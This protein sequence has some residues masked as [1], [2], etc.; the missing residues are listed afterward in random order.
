MSTIH[1][2]IHGIFVKTNGNIYRPAHS[3]WSYLHGE[4]FG[5]ACDHG[6]QYTTGMKVKA[7]A[8]SQSPHAK[9]G[10]EYWA[11]HD[12][13]YDG[14]AKV[15]PSTDCWNPKLPPTAVEIAKR[16]EI[17]AAFNLRPVNKY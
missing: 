7:H 13:Y 8:I 3:K 14:N 5:K 17:V 15:K 9:V 4:N 1:C 2:D 11:S 16:K 6:S 12:S 10:D